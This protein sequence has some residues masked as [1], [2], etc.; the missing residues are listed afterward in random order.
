MNFRIIAVSLMRSL[1]TCAVRRLA[2]H[3]ALR[4]TSVHRA[5]P[6][7]GPSCPRE[8]DDH[9]GTLDLDLDAD[10]RVDHRLIYEGIGHVR[11]FALGS[12]LPVPVVDERAL[13]KM[14]SDRVNPRRR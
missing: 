3:R 14:M 10:E 8:L 13:L 12:G 6:R 1:S 9:N 4:N 5:P 11:A 2:D 7:R